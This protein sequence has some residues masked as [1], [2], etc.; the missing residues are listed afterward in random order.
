MQESE[1]RV[2]VYLPLFR[3][4]HT[5]LH[6]YVY[7]MQHLAQCDTTICMYVLATVATLFLPAKQ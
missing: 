3:K 1:L 5:W 6:T 2:V 4:K 7:H